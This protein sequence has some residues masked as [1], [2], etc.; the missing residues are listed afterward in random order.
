[1]TDAF[2]PFF[3]APAADPA[4]WPDWTLD[5]AV[6]DEAFAAAHDALTPLGR[7]RIKQTLARMFAVHAPGFPVRRRQTAGFDPDLAIVAQSAPRPFAVAAVG[8]EFASPARLLAACLPAMRA[9]VDRVAVVRVGKKTPWPAPL[10]AALELCGVETAF[11][12]SP[13][14]AARFFADLEKSAPN[15]VV[16]DFQAAGR[17][18][19]GLAVLPAAPCGEIGVWRT[20]VRL[21][22]LEALAV[23]Q[24]GARVTVWGKTGGLPPGMAAGEG[25]FAA[26]LSRGYEAVFVPQGKAEAALDAENGPDLVLG[27]GMEWFWTCRGVSAAAFMRM[28]NAYLACPSGAGRER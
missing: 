22:D 24:A 20:G 19:A 15:G 27:P 21:F 13:G 12:F 26:F 5:D 25:D 3:S 6:P 23:A 17:V 10:L 28:K 14:Q 4:I 7:A 9:R 8:A 16:V 2:M 1:M 11:S 18:A